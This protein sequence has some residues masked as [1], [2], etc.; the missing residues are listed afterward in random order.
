MKLIEV[1]APGG[2]V[3]NT[4]DETALW[5]RELPA[6][7]FVPGKVLRCRAVVS[8]PSSNDDDTLALA[9]KV[10]GTTA[11]TTAAV[12]QADGDVAI[13]DIEIVAAPDAL[14]V[15]TLATDPDA[16]GGA[17]KG[18]AAIVDSLDFGGAIAIEVTAT[19]SVAHEDNVAEL[20]S[21]TVYEAA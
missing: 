16:S 9:V 11:I 7:F 1:T 18:Y 15:S 5:R 17:A 10:G 13:M 8:V 4:T 12:D 19:W 2:S 20:A 14:V 3:T 21:A 6:N